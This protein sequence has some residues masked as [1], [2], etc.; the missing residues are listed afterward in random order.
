MLTS[1]HDLATG[2]VSILSWKGKLIGRAYPSL[3]MY[4]LLMVARGGGGEKDLS[5]NGVTTG[6][7]ARL[8]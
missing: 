4:V 8:L 2:P 5:I 6:K 1:R 3:R 7:V